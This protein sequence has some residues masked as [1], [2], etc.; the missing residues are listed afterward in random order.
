MPR[1]LS[2]RSALPA[3]SAGG[4][5]PRR[6][7]ESESYRERD[8]LRP[9]IV[10]PLERPAPVE[11]RSLRVESP[12]TSTVCDERVPASLGHRVHLGR[13]PPPVPRYLM[14]GLKECAGAGAGG[15]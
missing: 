7:R 9:P 6:T 11:E 14:A 15:Q 1:S 12:L 2:V 10:Y 5:N 13:Y 3:P 8:F 4:Q